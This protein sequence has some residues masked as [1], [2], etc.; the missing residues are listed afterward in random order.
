LRDPSLS[1]GAWSPDPEGQVYEGGGEGV[2]VVMKYTRIQEMQQERFVFKVFFRSSTSGP[3]EHLIRLWLTK[4]MPDEAKFARVLIHCQR[5]DPEPEDGDQPI[6]AVGAR[7]DVFW[8]SMSEMR[9]L[10]EQFES[11][12]T[13]RLTT[14]REKNQLKLSV[15]GTHLLQLPESFVTESIPKWMR[16][17]SSTFCI[18]RHYQ[19]TLADFIAPSTRPAGLLDTFENFQKVAHHLIKGL[20]A[21]HDAGVLLLDIKADNIFIQPPADETLRA[22]PDS[23][24]IVFGDYGHAVIIAR[25]A[26]VYESGLSPA[27][28]EEYTDMVNPDKQV[29]MYRQSGDY[30]FRYG[31]RSY[32]PPEVQGR[33]PKDALYGRCTDVFALGLLLSELALGRRVSEIGADPTLARLENDGGKWYAETIRSALERSYFESIDPRGSAPAGM[34]PDL[35]KFLRGMV[36]PDIRRRL[37]LALCMS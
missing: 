25:E 11:S 34:V 1:N 21:H 36:H 8:P 23:W 4:Q 31:T 20:Q 30:G 13:S 2:C 33:S 24:E 29:E 6:G 22:D 26:F 5:R 7:Q 32:R 37:P 27:S 15:I 3:Q 35:C 18:Y 19:Y 16:F 9:E 10:W 28:G 12:L 14:E 17:Y